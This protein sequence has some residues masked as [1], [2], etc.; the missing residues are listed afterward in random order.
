MAGFL[1]FL[2]GGLLNSLPGILGGFIGAGRERARADAER[3]MMAAQIEADYEEKKRRAIEDINF[4]YT[5]KD[6]ALGASNV[7]DPYSKQKKGALMSQTISNL[8]SDRNRR[9]SALGS[10]GSGG[11]GFL[12][13]I[14]GGLFG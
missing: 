3:R 11:G 8:T 9:M 13:S 4:N 6:I 12:S 5:Q 1:G 2:G 7:M 14:F 10:G